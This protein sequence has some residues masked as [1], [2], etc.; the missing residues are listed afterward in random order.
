[1][2]TTDLEFTALPLELPQVPKRFEEEILKNSLNQTQKLYNPCDTNTPVPTTV[3]YIEDISKETEEA[4]HRDYMHRELKMKEGT[5]KSLHL[6]RYPV[7]GELLEWVNNNITSEHLACSIGITSTS[8]HSETLGPHVG[9]TRAFILMYLFSKGGD[10]DTRF[11]QMEGEP[12]IYGLCRPVPR[13]YSTLS[14]IESHRFSLGRWYI[15]NE[16]ILHDVHGIRSP[17][18]SLQI[19]LGKKIPTNIEQQISEPNRFVWSTI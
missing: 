3:K 1:M 15:L 5:V 6:P 9:L 13:D 8:E 16:S 11:Y 7:D 12:R 4:I 2:V 19:S 18:I 14:L 17:R 10:V